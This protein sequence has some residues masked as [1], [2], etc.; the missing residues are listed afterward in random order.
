MPPRG[1]VIAVATAL[2]ESQ[3]ASTCG[4]LGDAQRPRL[5]RACSSSAPARAGAP[6]RRSWTRSTRSTKFYEKLLTVAGWQTH[7]AD[8]GRAGGAAQRLPRRV[9]QA[10]AARHA[11]RQRP[12]RRRGATSAV[13]GSRSRCVRRRPDRRLRLDRAGAR[14]D[15]G[16][17]FRTADRPDPPRRR[18]HRAS[19]TADPRRGRRRVLVARCDAGPLPTAPLGLRPRRRPTRSRLRLVRRHPARRQRHHPLLPHGRAAAASHVGQQVAAGQH[20]GMVGTTGNSSGP[21][22]HFEVHLNGDRS[23]A[24]AIDPVPFM[25]GKGAPLGQDA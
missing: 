21:H 23:S 2:Q 12:G 5:A 11:D 7:A 20:I 6:R 1:W 15:V 13:D 9:R 25:R 16:S 24:G 3:P 17:G 14:A 18:P 4:D 22:L 10:R 8:R 19:G